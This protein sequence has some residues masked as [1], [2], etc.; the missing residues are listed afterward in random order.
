MDQW[1]KRT[2]K[3]QGKN[4][5]NARTNA[6]QTE[7]KTMGPNGHMSPS[8]QKKL[9]KKAPGC[10]NPYSNAESL[11]RKE[12]LKQSRDSQHSRAVEM[13]KIKQLKKRVDFN[14]K[15]CKKCT[16]NS[17]DHK[18]LH[19]PTC[20]FAKVW[21]PAGKVVLDVMTDWEKQSLNLPAK[22][23][24]V[25]LG[26]LPRSI[27]ESRPPPRNTVARVETN[28]QLGLLRR[29]IFESRPPPQNTVASV[30][31]N[32]VVG[33]VTNILLATAM[34]DTRNAEKIDLSLLE[35]LPPP[36][37]P[38]KNLPL[39]VDDD[40]TTSANK[41]RIQGFLFSEMM[42]LLLAKVLPL[43]IGTHQGG[44]AI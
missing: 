23:K 17:P 6:P 40:S 2:G 31:T 44:R 13:T 15:E 36:K 3:L 35:V 18:K 25:Q 30:E 34:N 39:L 9:K 26:L 22:N 11:R 8:R 14:T 7:T 32:A 16:N 38:P 28:V 24:Y 21:A 42:A 5:S 1:L 10:F 4:S 27:F 12:Q 19:Q 43:V 20:L 41:F 33:P 37:L 29:S